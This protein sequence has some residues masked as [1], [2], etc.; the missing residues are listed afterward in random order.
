[1]RLQY[2]FVELSR[3]TDEDLEAAVNEWVAQGWKL[4]DIRF[5][6]TDHSRRP[7]MAYIS[8]TREADDA[9][10]GEAD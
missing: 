9:R 1:M 8:F 10:G 5:V 3:V 2:K 6:V 4:D 7:A